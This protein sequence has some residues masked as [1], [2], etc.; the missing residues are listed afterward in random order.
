MLH[1]TAI[2]PLPIQPQHPSG[3]HPSLRRQLPQT[4]PLLPPPRRRRNKRKGEFEDFIPGLHPLLLPQPDHT[5][6]GLDLCP[7]CRQQR[8]SSCQRKFSKHCNCQVLLVQCVCLQVYCKLSIASVIRT[9][10]IFYRYTKH[11]PTLYTEKCIEKKNEKNI[12]RYIL[13][14]Y[15]IQRRRKIVKIRF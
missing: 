9:R 14:G 12:G 7:R 6:L 13:D 10:I 5:E 1:L 8:K 4:P 2:H 3:H 11:I 15:W